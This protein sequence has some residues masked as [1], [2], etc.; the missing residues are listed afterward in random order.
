VKMS[1]PWKAW[2][3]AQGA[4]LRQVLLLFGEG[5]Q[6]FAL[7]GGQEF[8]AGHE[9]I[10]TMNCAFEKPLS[11]ALSRRSDP[12]LSLDEDNNSLLRILPIG[13]CFIFQAVSR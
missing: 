2:F 9:T 6:R 8:T 1:K 13:C 7:S 4:I 5:E 10:L 11:L 12:P 3:N